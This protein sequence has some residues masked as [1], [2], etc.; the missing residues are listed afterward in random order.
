LLEVHRAGICQIG[1]FFRAIRSAD[2]FVAGCWDSHVQVV[3]YAKKLGL[4]KVMVLED[5]FQF[6]PSRDIQHIVN[7][8]SEALAKLPQDKWTRLSMGHISWFKM[9]YASGV[10]RASSVLTHAQIWSSRGLEW[11]STHEYDE[12]SKFFGVQVDG[13]ISYKLPFSYNMNPMVAFQRNE[14]SDRALNEQIL[15]QQG[16]ESTQIWI[17]IVWALGMLVAFVLAVLLLKCLVHLS[18]VLSLVISS[19]IFIIPFS[20]VWALILMEVF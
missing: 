13:F 15:E 8:V 16:L 20:L 3:T 2:G 6:D 11:M 18:L 1:K 9:Y 7:Q 19:L 14:G 12:V 10:E 4:T 5:D 17:P